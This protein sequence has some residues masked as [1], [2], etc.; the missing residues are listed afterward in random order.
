[1]RG[2]GGDGRQKYKHGYTCLGSAESLELGWMGRS[3]IEP[4]H[5]EFFKW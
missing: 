3:M 2:R 4:K 5:S 1:M